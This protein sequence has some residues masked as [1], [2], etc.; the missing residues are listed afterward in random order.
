MS[1]TTPSKKTS[2]EKGKSYL[3]IFAGNK[4]DT[5]KVIKGIEK[6]VADQC[7]QKVIERDAISRLSKQQKRKIKDLEVKHDA[8][9]IVQEAVGRISIRGDA[10]DVLDVATTIHEILNQKIE[11]EHTRGVKELVSKNTQWFYYEDYG[12]LEPYDT[13]INLQI[14][15]AYGEGRNSVVV[16]IEEFR[17]EIV[18]KDMKETCLDDGEKRLVVRKEIGKGKVI[19]TTKFQMSSPTSCDLVVIH[20]LC[21][22]NITQV[23]ENEN[24]DLLLYLLFLFLFFIV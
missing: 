8:S 21:N 9:V 13:S 3:E 15:K 2:K 6:D 22:V 1:H 7:K 20:F 16:L 4:Q 23:Q 11:E 17:Y 12:C 14:E 18:F 19:L 10:E 5:D 24:I